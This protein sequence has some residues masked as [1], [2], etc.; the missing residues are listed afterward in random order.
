M[1]KHNLEQSG[2]KHIYSWYANAMNKRRPGSQLSFESFIS[3]FVYNFYENDCFINIA[4]KHRSLG[5]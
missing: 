5:W 2:L 4:V 1:F 3:H